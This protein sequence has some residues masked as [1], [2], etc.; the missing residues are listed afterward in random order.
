MHAWY[1]LTTRDMGPASRCINKDAPPSQQWQHP[2]PWPSSNLVNFDEVKTKL[3]ELLMLQ[4]PWKV[5]MFI[6]LAW[7]C[8]S[9]F[10]ATDYLG[11]CNGARVRFSPQKDWD[12]NVNLDRVLKALSPIKEQYAPSQLSWA[13]LIILAG[14]TAIERTG[15][16]K[17]M[18]C[19]GRTD[20]AEGGGGPEY[21]EPRIGSGFQG[22]DLLNKLR[23][24]INLSGLSL[25][26]FCLLYTSDAADE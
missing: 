24:S 25:R 10:R 9:T 16:K 3:N 15:G 17:M 20:A 5:G 18:F 21:L 11:G 26:E 1:K 19:G 6:R 22:T 2:L 12:V 4:V 14:S 8:S 7:Q 13:D 23:E